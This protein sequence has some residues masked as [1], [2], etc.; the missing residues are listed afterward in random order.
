MNGQPYAVMPP[1]L[2]EAQALRRAGNVAGGFLVAILVMRA[3]IGALQAFGALSFLSSLAV[4]HVA[5]S[6][7]NMILYVVMLAVPVLVVALLTRRHHHRPFYARSVSGG[8]W[9]MALGVGL[10]F[11]IFAN[12]LAN[13]IANWL[14][15]FGVPMPQFPETVQPTVISLLLNLLSTAVLPAI[16]EEMI[17]RGYVLGV[18]RPHGDG[19][20]IVISALLFA[21]LHGN[22]LQ[23][24][25]AF[26][27]GLIMGYICVQTDNIWVAVL[28]HF[29]NNAM[30]V[31]ISFGGVC[32]PSMKNA[33]SNTVMI[34]AAAIGL[35]AVVAVVLR[36]GYWRTVGNGVSALPVS[37][38][39]WRLLC[40]PWMIIALIWLLW[41]I[42]GTLR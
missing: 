23:V 29:A 20:A 24:P 41:M 28:I 36:K 16:I 10:F 26:V 21:L 42:G 35:I 40:A 39:V 6:L 33:I 7:L 15:Q 22:I 2:A 4:N 19:L 13:W 32:Y 5:E 12:L 30:S 37:G 8:R 3:I 34:A 31:F 14:T 38:R 17:F 1:S 18:L 25:F 11:A 9:V 27:L